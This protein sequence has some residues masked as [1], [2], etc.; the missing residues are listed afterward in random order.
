M[1]SESIR[2]QARVA[3]DARFSLRD[4]VL[5]KELEQLASRAADEPD[6][7]EVEARLLGAARRLHEILLE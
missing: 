7:D 4:D 1:L 2:E 3:I 5:I 6:V